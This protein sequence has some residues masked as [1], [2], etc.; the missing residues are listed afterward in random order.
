MVELQTRGILYNQRG[1]EEWTF[2]TQH[3]F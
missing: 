2:Y 1:S 3:F